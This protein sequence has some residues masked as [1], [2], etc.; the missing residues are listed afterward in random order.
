L[1]LPIVNVNIWPISAV[2]HTHLGFIGNIQ[3]Y[4]LF[5]LIRSIDQADDRSVRFTSVS[6]YS[7]PFH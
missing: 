7:L 5:Y 1:T 3:S 2:A 4:S 6:F